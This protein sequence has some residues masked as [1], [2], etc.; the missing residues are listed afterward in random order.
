MTDPF[1]FGST[2]SICVE[3]EPE[4]GRGGDGETGRQGGTLRLRSSFAFRGNQRREIGWRILADRKVR[5]KVSVVARIY[6]LPL[7]NNIRKVSITSSDKT[8]QLLQDKI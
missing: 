5:L 1:V 2:V 7:L 4:R 8:T 3:M 6:L